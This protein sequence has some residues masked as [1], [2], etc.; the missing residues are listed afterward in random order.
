VKPQKILY[1]ASTDEHLIRFH[2][3]YI[4]ALKKTHDVRVMGNGS[5]FDL[6]A[7]FSKSLF[8]PKNLVALVRIHGLLRHE[9]FDLVLA[10]TALASFLVRL[11]TKGMRRPPRITV[12]VH[13][14][15]F[16]KRPRSVRERLFLLCEQLVKRQTD[17]LLVMNREDLALAKRYD[18]SHGEIRLIR[19]MGLEGKIRDTEPLHLRNRL[20]LLPEDMLCLYVGEL[21][22]RKNQMFLIRAFHSLKQRGERAVLLLVGNGAE[23]KALLREIQRR[24]LENTVYLLGEQKKIYSY[25]RE[26]DLYVSASRS[27]GLPFNILEA[28]EIWLPILASRIKGHED[29]LGSCPDSLYPDGDE[30]AFCK[31]LIERK[32][33]G[34]L[35]QGSHAYPNLE[36]YRLASVFDENLALLKGGKP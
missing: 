8:S 16:A 27:E 29:L 32:R 30:E 3:P 5:V 25:L 24:H 23:R 31:C 7:P 15:L 11:A 22:Q 13:G 1:C 36:R 28:M 33:D 9:H 6:H 12:T 18:L 26:T 10:H 34:R 4:Q 14:Y 35:G 21:S 20:G 17:L 19:G 2:L